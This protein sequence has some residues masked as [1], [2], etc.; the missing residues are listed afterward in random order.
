LVVTNG[1]MVANLYGYVGYSANGNNT[2][3]TVTGTNSQWRNIR[4]LEVGDD[5]NTN[6]QLVIRDGGLVTSR[7]GTIGDPVSANWNTVLVADAGSMWSNSASLFVGNRGGWNQLIVTN[8]GTVQATNAYVGFDASSTNNRAIVDGGNLIVTNS[9]GTAALDIRRGTNV[10][11][12]GLVQTDNLLLNTSDGF[13]D[14]N[15]GTLITHG[16]TVNKGL[17]FV[18]GNGSTAA[19][20]QLAGNGTHTF[21]NGLTLSGFGTLTGNGTVAGLL[22]VQNG[23]TISPGNSIG[24]LVLNSS[25][26]LQG[27]VFMEISKTGATLTNDQIQVTAS[28]TYGGSLVV[29]NLGPDALT[30]GDSFTLFSASSYFNSFTNVSLPALNSG[31]E[32]TNKLSTDGS[33]AVVVQ[34]LPTISGVVKSGTN[35]L[36]DVS[37]GSAGGAFTLLTST[38]VTLPLS[39]WTTNSAGNFD[40]LGNTTLT[41]GINP[42]EAQRY[43][44]VRVP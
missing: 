13:F 14:F 27:S 26:V 25:P 44:N 18:V 6:S 21:N 1:G 16:T 15:G 30:V 38:N 39:T 29:S 23:G 24:K 10:L 31:L 33:I 28:L 36:F 12:A 37:G 41:N 20:Y 42:N 35:L 3:V 40:G 8:G 34:V 11:N 7:D 5:A 22:T 19:T 2:R 4:D 43:F 32:W 9:G 17:P